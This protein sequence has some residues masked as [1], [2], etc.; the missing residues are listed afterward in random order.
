MLR[1]IGLAALL[2]V[3]PNAWAD[4]GASLKILDIRATVLNPRWVAADPAPR[5]RA[6]RLVRQRVREGRHLA[7]ADHISVQHQLHAVRPAGAAAIDEL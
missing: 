2:C 1:R 7:V 3:A 5:R 4:A 6:G